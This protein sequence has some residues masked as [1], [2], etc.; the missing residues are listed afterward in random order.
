MRKGQPVSEA[1]KQ[2][3]REAN[4]GKH[5]SEET[6]AKRSLKLRGK[7]RSEETKQRMR[8]VWTGN[9]LSSET[10]EKIRQAH[11]GKPLSEEHK[12]KIGDANSRGR[13]HLWKGGIS[14]EPYSV[15]WT[16]TLRRAIRERD[17]YICQICSLYGFYVHH[18]DYDK[19]NCDP[20]NLI[21]LCK[22]CHGKTNI[23]RGYWIQYFKWRKENESDN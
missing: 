20:E 23:N 21:T 5:P 3:L 6:I 22:K 15:D 9:K 14:F 17:N 12:R 4:L 1:L 10:K 11:L 2:R 13:C 16:K 19:K 18:I 7:K 8:E